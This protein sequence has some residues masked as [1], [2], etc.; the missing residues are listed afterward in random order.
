MSI[1][2]D[3]LAIGKTRNSELANEECAGRQ[4]QYCHTPEVIQLELTDRCNAAC[5]MC[6][7]YYKGNTQ[8]QDLKD[9]VLEKL[10]PLMANCRMMLMNGYGEPFISKKY[11]QCVDMLKKYGVKA[12]VT[13]NLSV[14]TE[15]MAH[16]AEEVFEQI[17]ISCHGCN[18]E[19]YERISRGLSYE[20]FCENLDR[21]ASL[22]RR[23]YLS[24]SVVAMAANIEKAAD[25]VRFAAAHK[26]PDIRFGRL[27]IN[28]FI[29]N[30]EQ[31][32]IHYSQA[33]AVYFHEAQE[34]ADRCGVNLVYPGNYQRIRPDTDAA[35]KQADMLQHLEFRYTAEHQSLIRKQYLR[36]LDKNNYTREKIP[37]FETG[38][39]VWGICDWVGKGLYIDKNGECF[40]CCESKEVSYGNILADNLEEILNGEKAVSVR[41]DFYEGRL[42][43]FCINCPFITNQE[44][45]MLKVEHKEELYRSPE[46]R[47]TGGDFSEES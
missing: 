14:F 41:T 43:Y 18:R 23:P 15:E 34:V 16:D 40:P 30:E 4:E 24:L 7:H 26:I 46:Y 36:T 35:R 32:L 37:P 39:K 42:P 8:A 2:A 19:D 20:R 9:G 1:I 47:R 5:I 10:E 12:F 21:L 45:Q 11:R 6:S 38:I 27:G 29:G 22:R 17:S 28:Q 25:F 3:S 31:D 33:A 44:L 13:T